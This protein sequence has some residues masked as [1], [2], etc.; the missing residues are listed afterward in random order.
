[1]NRIV[2]QG[3]VWAS[4]VFLPGLCLPV[5]GFALGVP[6]HTRQVMDLAD[7]LNPEEEQQIEQSL[8]LF[9]KEYGPQIQVLTIPSLEGEPIESY[10]IKVV[11]AWKLGTKKKDDGVLLLVV[12]QDHE[13]R[14]EVGQGLEGQLPDI[15]A[16][17]IIRDVMVP[18]FK[19]ER[20]DAGIF[21][22]LNAIASRLGGTLK[23]V[24]VFAQ[25]RPHER[26]PGLGTLLFLFIFFFII[27]PR[28]FGGG[29]RDR[30]GRRKNRADGLLTGMIL[31]NIFG[32][33]R[34][35]GGD[36]GGFGGFGGGGGGGFSGGGASGKW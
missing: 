21:S 20:F 19:K 9:Q 15:L 1:M 11:D 3:L 13:V 34:R 6:P 16:G 33:D 8:E 10:S 25:Q 17:R 30:F 2:G 23:N 14:I 31:G 12:P 7:V 28:L 22:G 5:L 32:S 27:L 18:F 4:L 26:S 24:P 29:G 36:S 35:G